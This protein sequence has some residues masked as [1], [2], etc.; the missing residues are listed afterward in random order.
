VIANTARG[1]G[2]ATERALQ[3]ALPMKPWT[4]FALLAGAACCG[5]GGGGDAEDV[6]IGLVDTGVPPIT[7]HVDT[8][9]G[10]HCTNDRCVMYYLNEGASDAAMFARQVIT[11]GSRILFD[12]ACLGDVD[13]L[14]RP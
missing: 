10:A 3:G 14:T 12:D 13:A 7:A 8:A 2:S 4:W 6:G 11:T 1:L 5:G 9:H